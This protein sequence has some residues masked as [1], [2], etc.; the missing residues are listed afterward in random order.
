M[1]RIRI[2]RLSEMKI[3][4]LI[5][6]SYGLI[7]AVLL[8]NNFIG[9]KSISD[10][11]NTVDVTVEDTHTLTHSM[12]LVAELKT[13]ASSLG[14]YLL[15][16]E[17]YQAEIFEKSRDNTYKTLASVRESL[18]GETDDEIHV[19]LDSIEQDIDRFFGYQERLFDLAANPQ[20]N[21]P[22]MQFAASDI[23]PVSLQILQNLTD[24]LFAE[25]EEES[26]DARKT[27][28]NDINELRYNWVRLMSGI[29][30][31]LAFRGNSSL[32]EVEMYRENIDKIIERI[33]SNADLLTFEQEDAL[34]NFESLKAGFSEKYKTLV[35][36]HGSEQW[37]QDVYIT[38]SELSPILERITERTGLLVTR[39]GSRA[40]QARE[41]ARDTYATSELQSYALLA[42]TALLVMLAGLMLTRQIKTRLGTDAFELQKVAD[43]IA[44]GELDMDLSNGGRKTTGVFASMQ[45]M[46]A[47]LRS[48]IERDHTVAAENGRIRQ[49]LDKADANIMITGRDHNIIYMNDALHDMMAAAES[50]I[51]KDM[52][53]F[54][55]DKLVGEN[56]DLF[57]GNPACQQQ[58]LDQ[59][60]DS[61]VENF[62]L[63]GRSMRVIASPIFTDEQ[64]RLGT[65]IQWID[66]T[67]DVQIENEIRHMVDAALNGDLSQRISVAEK[68]D[69]HATLSE[70]INKLIEVNDRVI[71]D[72]SDVMEAMATGDLTRSI[73]SDYRGAFA[74]LKDNV[75][76][77]LEK[78]TEIMLLINESANT[79]MSG[80]NE[81][82]ASNNDLSRRTEEQAVSLDEATTSM[83]E[84]T[85]SV[86]KNADNTQHAERLAGSARESA[87]E[88][89][90]VVGAAIT[91][92]GEI[93]NSSKRI[94]DIISVIDEIA[95]QTNLLA[96]N[97]AVEAARA[98]EQGR[99]FAVVA[100][101]VRTL[102]GRSA[103]S[104]QEIKHLIQDSVTRVEEGSKLVDDTG[105]T[106]GEIMGAVQEVS[107]LITDIASSSKQQSSGIEQ[108]N[109]TISRMDES[110][111]Q[112]AALVE[113]AA[114]ASESMGDQARRLNELIGF[115]TTRE[116]PQMQDGEYIERRS[117]TRPWGSGDK[118]GTQETG[119]QSRPGPAATG[120][121]LAA[122]GTD[123]S[124]WKEF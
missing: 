5:W 83:N 31:F 71:N 7:I 105:H 60:T 98:G 86:Q 42:I 29:R 48:Q 106:L 22:A 103:T 52:P 53:D 33:Y 36:M 67:S 96:L 87:E 84:M 92:M 107:D 66:R 50:D 124:A 47:N 73:S 49:A 63:G 61:H 74:R 72:V 82:A 88:G 1:N 54:E 68:H 27:L 78:L 80:S 6:A 3:T 34:G 85:S 51:Q 4:N 30:A 94:A 75:N 104:A 91:A 37:R 110:T 43:A 35:E 70:S 57:Q 17:T 41:G 20:K 19:L 117:E 12:Q 25:G 15:G 108:V 111:Q 112:N 13:A 32:D 59:L 40:N 97:A 90:R 2:S 121:N 23:N 118:S 38:K 120:N 14:Y 11:Y 122:D 101:E 26:N 100:A 95:F 123:D 62:E 44:R 76:A 18:A 119:T 16:Q 115:F 81:I 24:M 58:I 109:E 69:F 89:G 55:V 46:Q 99:G 45:V 39:L 102:A 9:M 113:Q 79:V 93:T 116:R 114:A 10:V 21:L 65:V 77:T 28:L 8:A 64:T 56:I